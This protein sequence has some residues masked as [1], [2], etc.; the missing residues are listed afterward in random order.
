MLSKGTKDLD[1][2]L[3][4]GQPSKQ[5]WGLGYKENRVL[6]S[7][8]SVS[9]QTCLIN[10]VRAE[11]VPD[12]KSKEVE[13]HQT[14]SSQKVLVEQ[15]NQK[16]KHGCYSCGKHGHMQRYC[17]ALESKIKSRKAGEHS[18]KSQPWMLFLWES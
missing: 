3:A 2:L 7:T 6:S 11:P 16:V 15:K 17:D 10:F 1:T 12:N 8:N 9:N 5:N 4:M 18:L 13:S 14:C